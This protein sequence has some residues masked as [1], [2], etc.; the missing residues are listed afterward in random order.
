M[1]LKSRPDKILVAFSY[2]FLVLFCLTILY[3][4]WNII[5]ISFN[6]SN[7]TARGGLTVF[8]REFTLENYKQVFKDTR[9]LGAFKISALR[10]IISTF[11]ATLFTS[12]FAYGI[13]RKQLKFRRFYLKYCTLTMYI[14]AG[15][16]PTYILFRSIHLINNFWVYVVPWLFS[17]YNMIIFK[18]FFENLSDGLIDAAKIDGAGEY[19]TFFKVV[20]PVSK[21]VYATLAL[22]VAVGQWNSWF[23]SVIYI[24]KSELLTLPALLRQIINSNT[25]E[26]LLAQLNVS[27]TEAIV[28]KISTRSLSSATMIV[29]VVPIILVY[30]FLQKYF[31]GGI[32]L[33]SIKE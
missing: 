23:D 17:A 3:P 32:M 2:I 20:I 12:M 18:S 9:L 33:G 27:A 15:L 6:E 16:I 10:T 26:Q 11:C 30:P 21:P 1:I 8:T 25:V 28:S 4:F 24:T 13:S 7:D 14:S 31:A 29:S 5:V 19:L 22:F